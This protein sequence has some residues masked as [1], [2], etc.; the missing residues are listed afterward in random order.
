M[1]RKPQRP[2]SHIRCIFPWRP[3]THLSLPF[4]GIVRQNK[5]LEIRG[6]PRCWSVPG[7]RLPHSD[8]FLAGNL[9]LG[10]TRFQNL[11]RVGK[12]SGRSSTVRGPVPEDP[13]NQKHDQPDH[14]GHYQQGKQIGGKKAAPPSAACKGSEIEI[15]GGLT[16]SALSHHPAYGSVPGGSNSLC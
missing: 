7:E 2:H 9:P 3:D 8:E 4:T 12:I 1:P 6:E 5:V 11:F 13:N 15:G 14:S 16:T 10:I